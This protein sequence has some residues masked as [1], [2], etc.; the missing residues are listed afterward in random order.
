MN[1]WTLSPFDED[2]VR[3]VVESPR[4]SSIKLEYL[5]EAEIFQVSRSLPLGMTYP[6]DWGFVPGTRADDGD[7]VDAMAIHFSSSF[8]GVILPCRLLGMVEV[9][10]RKKSGAR[11]TNNRLI[12]TP[13]WHEP[14]RELTDARDLPESMRHELEQFFLAVTA[15]THK[16][17]EILGWEGARKAH[18]FLEQCITRP[19]AK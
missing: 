7:P 1:L 10:E 2:A 3:V 8:P 12:V 9:G 15:F 4:G 13:A 19:G 6:F 11:Q 5:P 14:L 18:R 17:V 16:K